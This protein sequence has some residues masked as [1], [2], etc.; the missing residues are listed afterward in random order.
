MKRHKNIFNHRPEALIAHSFIFAMLV[1][2]AL[3]MLPCASKQ[4]ALSWIDAL[5]MATSAVCVTGLSVVDIGK[6]L[7]L[8]GQM[9]VLVLIQLGGLGIMTFSLLF[10]IVLGKRMTY[11]FRQC[12]PE[13]TQELSAQ[14]VRYSIAIILS[15]ALLVQTVGA[16]LLFISLRHYHSVPY[17]IYSSC[18]H[19]I[20]AFCNAGIGLYSDSLMGFHN[21]GF[22]LIIIMILIVTGG[23]GFIVVYEIVHFITCRKKNGRKYSL[24]LHTKIAVWGSA[25]FIFGGA[26]VIWL[27]ESRG[28]MRL[29]P[30]KDQILNSFFLAVTSRTAGFNTVNIP[31]FSTPTLILVIFLMFIGGCPGSTAGG[32]KI[33]TFFT[34]IALIKDKLRGLSMASLFKRKLPEDVVDRALMLFISSALI[35]FAAMF[36]MQIAENVTVSH[37]YVLERQRFLDI[38]FE[39]VSAFGTVGL[40]TGTTALLSCPGKVILILLMLI[41]RVGPLTLGVALQLRAKKTIVYE[42]PQEEIAIS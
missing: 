36:A 37:L 30:F 4:E 16:C 29:L 3:L 23:L 33:H 9:V 11:Q 26:L 32:V 13:F 42:Y 24:S 34:V 15:M 20:S 2:M 12:V 1:G 41:G 17:A 8:F 21:N 7:T 35:V 40:S 19:A 22:F 25:I 5:F 38:L 10:M 27:L 14:N 6:D 28:I 31:L 39:V 18:F